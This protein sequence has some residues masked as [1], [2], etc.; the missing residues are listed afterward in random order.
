MQ[1]GL[2][3]SVAFRNDTKSHA[4]IGVDCHANNSSDILTQLR[5]GMQHARAAENGQAMARGEYPSVKIKVEE[6]FNL[7]TIQ[8]AKAI[9]M[10]D[11]I[12]S[13]EVG[14]R[15]DLVVFDAS[16]PG[17]VCAAEEDPVAAVLMHAGVGDV[18]M[19]IV[20]GVVRKEGGKLAGVRFLDELNSTEMGVEMAWGEVRS[21]LL[22]SR[23]KIRTKG[24]GQD[25]QAAM[26]FLYKTFG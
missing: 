5:L 13:I 2:G 25:R 4:S 11:E 1:M 19:V 9:N 10:E 21:R 17:M 22:E 24:Q 15:A 18:E 3:E 7:G 16:S 23:E 20:D 8:G 6:A 14:K 26:Q 12:G